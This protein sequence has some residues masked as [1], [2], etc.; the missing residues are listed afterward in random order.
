MFDVEKDPSNVELHLSKLG[1]LVDYSA[2]G[3]INKISSA[4]KQAGKN[5]QV[6]TID[7]PEIEAMIQ[8]SAS[9]VSHINL[10]A[11]ASKGSSQKVEA[12]LPVEEPLP[13]A[14]IVKVGGA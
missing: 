11:G 7:C 5:F 9:L 12:P 2:L 14:T 13:P 3:A 1:A 6:K 4:Y 10:L 8:D